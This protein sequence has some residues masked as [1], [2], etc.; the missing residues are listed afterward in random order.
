[1]ALS[2]FP[3]PAGGPQQESFRTLF[4][5]LPV[6]AYRAS[7]S[8]VQ[9]R[10]NPAL[11]RLHGYDT[12]AEMLAAI[13]DVA[14]VYVEPG[15]WPAF[16]ERL[17]RDGQVR[18]F[19][20][21]IRRHRTGERIWISENAHLVRDADGQ[22]AYY[23][24]T[25]EEV[26]ARVRQQSDLER[27]LQ[28]LRQT[29][30]QLPA[31]VYRLH[32]PPGREA[33]PYFSFCSAGVRRVYGIEPADVLADATAMT[34]F[35]HPE[36]H[37]RVEEMVN[38][39][40]VGGEPLMVV[41]RI[42]VGGHVKW[43]QMSSSAAFTEE[44]VQVRVGVILD[45]TAQREAEAAL[46]ERDR[47]EQARREMTRFLSRVSHELRTPLNAILGFAQLIEMEPGTPETQRRWSRALLDSGR[48]LLE[49]VNEVLDLS[50]AQ[51]GQMRFDIGTVD[52]AD[53]IGE[54]WAMVQPEAD[55]R[56][57]RFGGVPAEP[58]WAL[59]QAD[60]RRLLQV[61]VN[62]LANAVKYNRQGGRIDL[63]LRMTP[64]AIELDVADTGEG[65]GPD[66][67]SRL[68]SPFER[69]GAQHGTLPG[70]GLGLAL[71]RQ[72]AQGMGGTLRA[73]STAGAGSVF[74]LRLPRSRGNAART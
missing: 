65:L 38:R 8:G 34:R 32:A 47:A 7:P 41:F 72:L 45:V 20:S 42:V 51:S 59:V 57:L 17:D 9:L 28:Y 48:H 50:G 58:G 56:R 6:G 18:A 11:A 21:E 27:N 64:S 16:C 15:R 22:V 74:T 49:L 52:L 66:Q 70:S 33:R 31:V 23:E 36:D 30:E 24:G 69:L 35:R 5:F 55:E 62:L 73:A 37:P 71:S 25:V 68:F 61:V 54:A 26:T 1:M 12:E 13:H 63:A 29:T 67:L 43:V 53:V 10:A 44:G 46:H 39:A 19:V 14:E 2:E 3:P 60:R 4:D 40:R